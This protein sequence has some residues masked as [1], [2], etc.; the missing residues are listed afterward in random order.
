MAYS[1]Y[2][3]FWKWSL[4]RSVYKEYAVI[5]WKGIFFHVIFVHNIVELTINNI[6]NTIVRLSINKF[7]LS[8][9]KW[10]EGYHKYVLWG[11]HSTRNGRALIKWAIFSYIDRLFPQIDDKLISLEHERKDKSLKN[12]W[13][14]RPIH[15]PPSPPQPRKPTTVV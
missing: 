15:P 4:Q 2:R 8:E 6:I 12:D 1:K 5:H 14:V 7:M 3:Y 10:W 13:F 9:I 11:A